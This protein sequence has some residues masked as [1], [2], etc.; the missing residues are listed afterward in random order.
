MLIKEKVKNQNNKTLFLLFRK[1]HKTQKVSKSL[2][3]NLSQILCFYLLFFIF[4]LFI[5]LLC[6]GRIVSTLFASNLHRLGSL[7]LAADAAQRKLCFVGLSLETYLEAAVKSGDAP[8]LPQELI[9]SAELEDIDPN[10]VLIVTTGT[11]IY[12]TF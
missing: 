2:I 4:I 7:K 1:K 10:E 6:L 9:G 5:C 12:M 8:F 11:V 3:L